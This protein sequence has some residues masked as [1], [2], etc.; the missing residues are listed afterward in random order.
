MQGTEVERRFEAMDAGQKEDD[1]NFA[2]FRTKH[3]I[4]DAQRTIVSEGIQPGE[5]APDFELPQVGGGTVRLS[6]FQRGR[7]TILHFGSYS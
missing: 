3:L 4:Y 1:Y 2:H 7:P 6:D 5:F